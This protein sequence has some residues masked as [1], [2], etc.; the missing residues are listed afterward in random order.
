MTGRARGVTRD[1]LTEGQTRELSPG[2]WRQPRGELGQS[3]AKVDWVEQPTVLLLQV[4]V[5]D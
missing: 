4:W 2:V 1:G 5:S 3:E